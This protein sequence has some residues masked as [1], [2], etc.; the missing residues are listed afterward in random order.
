[1]SDADLGA[2][3]VGLSFDGGTLQTAA[4][5]TSTRGITLLP[6]GGTWDTEDFNSIL[7]G[8]ISG[9]GTLTKMGVGTLILT[10]SNTYSGGT[11]LKG[12]ILK[13]SQDANLG[14]ATGPLTFNGGTLQVAG[15]LTTS[16]TMAVLDNGG[17]FDT[18]TFASVFNGELS[19]S[20]TFTQQGTGSLILGGDGSPF[21]EPMP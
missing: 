12:G 10:G 3:S 18:G 19:G 14:A 1:M 2:A 6:D 13:V 5:F 17:T 8:V 20:G 15:A 7:S 4:D 11:L 9:P 16:R 21:R